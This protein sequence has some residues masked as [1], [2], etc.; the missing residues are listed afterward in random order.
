MSL[1]DKTNY[2]QM[3]VDIMALDDPGILDGMYLC[4]LRSN[5]VEDNAQPSGRRFVIPLGNWK[6][7][8]IGVNLV[9]LEGTKA[10]A[11]RTGNNTVTLTADVFTEPGCEMPVINNNFAGKKHT[12]FYA[13]GTIAE[14]SF[15][16]AIYKL[17]VHDR[18]CTFWRDDEHTFPGEPVFVPNTS[19]NGKEDDGVL[20][21]AMSNVKK[22]E[23]DVLVFIDA[24][25][26]KEI[27]RASFKAHIPG[28]LHGV[29]VET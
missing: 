25:N 21:A 2:S 9:T 27:A 18:S 7:K 20:I 6:D 16:N 28:A 14:N 10:T 29:F 15:R 3:V 8:T 11:V 13:N 12:Y 19:V 22:G 5:I 24:R 1:I 17:N 26:M 23:D 4:K